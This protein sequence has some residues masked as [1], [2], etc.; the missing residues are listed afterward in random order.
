MGLED[1][2]QRPR[3]Q[4]VWLANKWVDPRNQVHSPSS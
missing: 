2:I 3:Y 4:M 1:Y